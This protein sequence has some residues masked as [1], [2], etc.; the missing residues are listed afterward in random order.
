MKEVK[1]YTQKEINKIMKN[2]KR[3][4]VDGH[5]KEQFKQVYLSSTTYDNIDQDGEYLPFI[6]SSYGRVFSL[7]YKK[8]K[9]H[10]HELKLINV[11]GY[12]I[13]PINFNGRKRS[14]KVHRLVAIAFI[15]NKNPKVKQKINHKN[16][17][18]TDNYYWNLE[19][20]TDKENVRHAHKTGLANNKGENNPENK[21]SKKQIKKVCSMLEENHSL[22]DISKKT[23]VEYSTIANILYRKNWIDVSKDYNFDNYKY[24]KSDEY[25]ETIENICKFGELGTMSIREISRRTGV[26]RYTVSDILTGKT[27]KNISNK[28][29]LSKYQSK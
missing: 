21:Y 1:I 7:N 11:K 6:I 26:N 29:N 5:K 9:G 28:Y 23:K 18:K 2:I 17:I 19:W 25:F 12:L 16:G 13:A 20:C 10:L 3:Q 22:K 8:K 15:K 4:H 24:G 14:V 27:H